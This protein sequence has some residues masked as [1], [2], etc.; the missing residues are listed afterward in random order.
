MIVEIAV[1]R[2]RK[3]TDFYTD[4]NAE[5]LNKMC[6]SIFVDTKVPYSYSSTC[7]FIGNPVF[8]LMLEERNESCQ[9]FLIL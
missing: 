7:R 9:H 6:E 5:F 3:R 1:M 4:L 2:G 8:G